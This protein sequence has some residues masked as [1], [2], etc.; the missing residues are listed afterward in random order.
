[1]NR[2][3]TLAAALALAMFVVYN[4]NG[5]EIGS[6]DSQPTKFAARELLLRG[7]LSLNYVVGFTPG[8]AKRSAFVETADGRYRS[9]YSPVPAVMAAA[10][11]WPLWRTGLI[12]IRA[13]RGPGFMA[14]L[15]SSLLVSLAVGL[16]FLTARTRL[17]VARS[18]ALAVG[19]GVGTGLWS[20][21]SQTLWQHETAIF[22]LSLAVYGLMTMDRGAGLRSGL[23]GVGL[24]L[25][26]GSRLQLMPAVTIALAGV[27]MSAGWR[28]AALA[29]A[30][31]GAVILPVIFLNYQWFG[32]VL[33]AAPILEALHGTV[34]RTSGSFALQ[35][36]GFAGLL[37]AP[38]RG[39]LVF[40]PIVAVA[41]L[42]IPRSLR[43]GWTSPHRWLVLAAAAQFTLYAFYTVWWGGH[44]FGPR[45]MLDILPLLVPAAAIG[46]ETLR[47]PT[48]RALAFV[49]LAWSVAV[50]A[51]GAFNYPH[52]RWNSDPVDVDIAHDRLW[53]VS[54]T[55]IRRAWLAG[56]SPQNFNLFTPEAV[57][58]PQP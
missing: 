48:R 26:A 9:A 49:A 25:A 7:T 44:T 8:L 37:V 57:R 38:N 4:A 58:V 53:N 55:Q 32:T 3:I 36:E 41:L 5:R 19:L 39:L 20:T 56:P 50:A 33:G 35:I 10:I 15:S 21:V 52:E 18:L 30:G 42:G 45:Y 51:L 24:G 17:S 11:A 13:P 22:G 28:R 47:T 27:A 1:M 14:A 54:D 29:A 46:M 16:A 6:Y 23:I 12:D 34:H 40:S 43:E 2:D 31:A